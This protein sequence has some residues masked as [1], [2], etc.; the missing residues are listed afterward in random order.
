MLV[1]IG[2]LV[3]DADVQPIMLLLTET[4][5]RQIAEMPPGHG[6]YCQFPAGIPGDQVRE[7]MDQPVLPGRCETHLIH[8]EA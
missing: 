1:K 6:M 3:F 7:W 4:E 5:K 8:N 2:L